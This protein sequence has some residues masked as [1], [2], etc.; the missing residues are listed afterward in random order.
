MTDQQPQRVTAGNA[1]QF[2]DSAAGLL[3]KY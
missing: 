3:K 2:A 1:S